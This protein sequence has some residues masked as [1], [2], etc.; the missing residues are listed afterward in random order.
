MEVAV[1]GSPS[2]IRRKVSVDV[3]QHWTRRVFCGNSMAF[4]SVEVSVGFSLATCKMYS[5]AVAKRGRVHSLF[6][7]L[8]IP[9]HRLTET[10]WVKCCFTFTESVGLLGD[11]GPGRPPRLSHSSWTLLKRVECS[12]HFKVCFVGGCKPE[13]GNKMSQ[14]NLMPGRVVAETRTTVSRLIPCSS[15]P[16]NERVRVWGS[17]SHGPSSVAVSC[18]RQPRG[19]WWS[20]V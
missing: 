1:L 5:F 11:G 4:G 8:L 9:W 12:P 18:R 3:K 14:C 19:S 20:E 13:A 10:G 2:P 15:W 6:C 17:Y 16:P 7:L